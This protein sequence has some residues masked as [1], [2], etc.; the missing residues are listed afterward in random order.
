MKP[1]HVALLIA[2]LV[3]LLMWRFYLWL[4]EGAVAPDPWPKEVEDQLNQSNAF[5]LCPRCLTPQV[6]DGRFCAECGCPTGL[7][8]N[9]NPYLYI[10]SVG[11][12]LRLGTSGS[13]PKN[14]FLIFGYLLFS[15]V[16]YTIF[17]PVYWYCLFRN[18]KRRQPEE[19][20]THA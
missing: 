19:L 8:N 11:D 13:I 16:E 15:A 2:G 9:L 14:S 20:P 17:A 18:L 10:F 1:E 4:K 3:T 6:E 12:A 7:F 5:P